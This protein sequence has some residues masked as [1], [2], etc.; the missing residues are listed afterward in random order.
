MKRELLIKTFS[1]FIFCLGLIPN[2]IVA[3]VQDGVINDPGDIAIVAY[4]PTAQSF[5][6]AFLDNCPANTTIVFTDEEW[7]G[8]AWASTTNEGDVRW[9]TTSAI[10]RGTVIHVQ[11]N[12][13]A[14]PFDAI[15]CSGNGANSGTA[16][17]TDSGFNCA[18]ADGITAFISSSGNRTGTPGAFLTFYGDATTIAT[19]F[20]NT[21]LT[22]G[23]NAITTVAGAAGG[24]YTGSTTC[25]STAIACATMINTSSNWTAGDG[26]TYPAQVAQFFSGSVLPIE[27]TAFD[28]Q[29]TEGSKNHLTWS[30]AS[31]KNNQGF[32]VERSADGVKFEK[33]GFVKGNGTSSETKQYTYEDYRLSSAVTY[34]RLKQVDFDGTFTY[35]KVVSVV[36][37][38]GTKLKAY[39]NPVA[40]VLMLETAVKGNYEVINLLGQTVLR[41]QATAQMIDVSALPQGNY[42]L[43]VGSEQVKF[44][45]Q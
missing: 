18:A 42:I 40:T 26:Y 24:R 27:L 36:G 15:T 33:I 37:E 2:S 32:E 16:S 31:E 43:K 4:N 45:K 39:P 34:Y 41:G 14:A 9:T 28:V 23:T 13:A 8:S 20:T 29:I 5:S 6:F 11:S 25:N 19:S 10:P 21:G 17:E 1:I 35:S 30:T 44:F 38:G 12:S 22:V 3:Q 7:S